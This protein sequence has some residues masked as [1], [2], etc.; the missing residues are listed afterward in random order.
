MINLKS[1]NHKP[2]RFYLCSFASALSL[3]RT[4]AIAKLRSNCPKGAKRKNLSDLVLTWV[5]KEP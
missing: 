1:K 2:E 5:F 4:S 3:L